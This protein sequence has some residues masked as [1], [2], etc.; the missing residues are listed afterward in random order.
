MY[1]LS[2][3]LTDQKSIMN[4]MIETSI[5]GHNGQFCLLLFC[6]FHHWLFSNPVE[7]P[8]EAEEGGGGGEDETQKH[9]AFLLEK[10][11]GCSVGGMIRLVSIKHEILNLF[12]RV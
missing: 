10:V 8:E 3:M 12:F 1:Q 4:A 2:H 6:K 7:G 11:E 9:L 5:T